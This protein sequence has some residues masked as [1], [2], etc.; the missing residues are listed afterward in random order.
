MQLRYKADQVHNPLQI[1]RSAGYKHFI[2][3]VTKKESYVLQL[4]NGFYPRFHLY[5]VEEEDEI[6]F[7][8]HLDQKKPSY[9]GSRAHG[10]EYDGPTVEKELSRIEGWAGH[11]AGAPLK[12]KTDASKTEYKDYVDENEI[13]QEE[14]TSE[15][16]F[17]GIFN[18]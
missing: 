3:P 10:G 7:D 18:K 4:T 2:D 17:Q 8:L 5:V 15:D 11:I 14:P 9:S 13:E 16:I 6:V 12:S 1:L